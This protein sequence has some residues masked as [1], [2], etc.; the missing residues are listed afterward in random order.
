MLWVNM[1]GSRAGVEGNEH[2]E[3]QQRFKEY[4][5]DRENVTVHL[6]EHFCN[7]MA[8]KVPRAVIQTKGEE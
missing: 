5:R 4:R 1:E 2:C 3:L 6:L 8:V 7:A